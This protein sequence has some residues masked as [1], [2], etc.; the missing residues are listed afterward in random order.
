MKS[1]G[2]A[3]EAEIDKGT[4]HVWHRGFIPVESVSD[5]DITETEGSE[6]VSFYAPTTAVTENY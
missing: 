5:F 2:Q 3:L 1:C 6:F 4:Q